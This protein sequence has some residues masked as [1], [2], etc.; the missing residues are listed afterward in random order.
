MGKAP[1]TAAECVTL[2]ADPKKMLALVLAKTLAPDVIL[3]SWA[4]GVLPTAEALRKLREVDSAAA[5]RRAA[6]LASIQA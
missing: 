5:V 4:A 6:A 1:E 2:A 3:A